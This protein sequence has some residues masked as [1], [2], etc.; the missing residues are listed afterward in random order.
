MASSGYRLHTPFPWCGGIPLYQ[1]EYPFQWK[2]FSRRLPVKFTAE[3]EGGKG[4][5]RATFAV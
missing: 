3:M 5:S 1:A 4:S 2:A